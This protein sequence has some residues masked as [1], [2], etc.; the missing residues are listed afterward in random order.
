MLFIL[1]LLGNIIVT[2]H[3]LRIKV[4]GK[5]LHAGAVIKVEVD[6]R[7][8]RFRHKAPEERKVDLLALRY[9]SKHLR[10]SD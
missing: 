7:T 2:F 1:N 10:E 6:R 3:C 5:P 9:G 4:A 8:G